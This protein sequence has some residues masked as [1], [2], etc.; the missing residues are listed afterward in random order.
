VLGAPTLSSP[1]HGTGPRLAGLSCALA[2][3]ALSA[4]LRAEPIPTNDYAIDVYQGPVLA[5]LRVSALGGAYAGYAEGIAGI[6]ANAAAPAVRDPYSVDDF[7]WDLS[8]SLSIPLQLFENDDFDNNGDVDA[9][10]SS[11]VYLSLGGMLQKGPFG[12]GVEAALQRYS[13]EASGGTT[14]VWL[15]RYHLLGAVGLAEHA[16]SIGAGARLVTMGLSTPE[17]ELSWVGAAPELGLLLRPNDMPFRFGFTYRFPVHAG[18][19][20]AAAQGPVDGLAREG[21]LVLPDEVVLPWELE[22]G[23]AIQAGPRPLNP[24]FESGPPG[25]SPEA[26]AERKRRA[27]SLPRSKLTLLASVLVSGPVERGVRL[28][29]FLAQPDPSVSPAGVVGSSGASIN[30]SPR[31]GIETE[32]LANLLA[33]RAGSYYEPNRSGGVGRQHFTFGGELRVVPFDWF[34]LVEEV[35]YS[36]ELGLDLAPRYESVSASIGVWR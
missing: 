30:F 36:L 10:Y 5:P 7:D 11:F 22:A 34:G 27:R 20:G 16:V 14:E 6:V 1:R 12:L 23:V 21:E 33:V 28:E 31:F 32:P 29:Q 26:R 24:S 8:A 9:D 25:E 19:V 3:C 15:G 17:A 35:D 2:A 4:E 13:L 18:G